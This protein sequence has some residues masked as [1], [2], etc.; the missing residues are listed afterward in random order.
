MG[1]RTSRRCAADLSTGRVYL[2]RSLSAPRVRV[3]PALTTHRTA[4]RGRKGRAVWLLDAPRTGWL[5]MMSRAAWQSPRTSFSVSATFLSRFV[6]F[7]TSSSLPI[8]A[9]ASHIAHEAPWPRR[10]PRRC[11]SCTLL[12]T[13][14]PE[15]AYGGKSSYRSA[16]KIS[17]L[18]YLIQTQDKIPNNLIL[19]TQAGRQTDRQPNPL[20]VILINRRT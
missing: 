17:N 10:C 18:I 1:N 19:S 11:C 2:R 3:T 16:I 5:I 9:S 20:I 13:G 8:S 7:R 12:S 14:K 15:A 4:V 6:L